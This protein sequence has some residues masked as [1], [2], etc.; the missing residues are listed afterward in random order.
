VKL[1]IGFLTGRN[2]PRLDWVIDDVAAQARPDDEIQIVVIDAIEHM[3]DPESSPIVDDR[4]RASFGRAP[5]VRAQVAPVRPNIWQG[6][7]R[8]TKQDWWSTAASRN[9]FLCLAEHDYIAFLDD[10]C[11]IGKR[12]LDTVRR[13]EQERCSAIT[14]SFE[15]TRGEVIDHR[16]VTYPAGMVDCT[17]AWLYGCTFCLPL[18][19]ALE[20]NGFEEGCDG[21]AGEDYMFGLM[22]ARRHRQ[23]DFS[24]SLHVI[25]DR[26]IGDESCAHRFRKLDKADGAKNIAAIARFGS[27]TST[28]FTPDLRALR[29]TLRAGGVFPIPDPDADW[30]DWFDGQ[31]IREMI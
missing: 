19:W 1:S 8:V 23:I 9:T 30:R 3:R 18:E 7:H 16:A 31:P 24:T 20:V 2:E 6:R 28:E 5:L 12:W 15:K 10:C 14:G 11:H 21:A 4:V 25:Q 29:E 27:R 22:L 26:P 13:A 17:G